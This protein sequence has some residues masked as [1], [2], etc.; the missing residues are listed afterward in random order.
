MDFLSNLW[1]DVWFFFT[2]MIFV[3]YLMA[4]TIKRGAL[5]KA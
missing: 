3:G 4:L 5:A 1:D 2:I